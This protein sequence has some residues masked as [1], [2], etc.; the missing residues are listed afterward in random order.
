MTTL[1]DD[2]F[3]TTLLDDLFW[4]SESA[5]RAVV[6]IGP[7]LVAA[8]V[9]LMAL[10]RRG[11]RWRPVLLIGLALAGMLP[12]IWW[13]SPL[14]LDTTLAYFGNDPAASL[15]ADRWHTYV[16][17]SW[18]TLLIDVA[19]ILGFAGI[20]AAALLGRPSRV[21]TRRDEQP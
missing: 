9:A 5:F 17:A 20:V 3:W 16:R 4:W 11:G 10:G 1:L 21:A 18:I 8:A 14:R 15:G 12:A 19:E 7:V 2:L 6:I 13:W